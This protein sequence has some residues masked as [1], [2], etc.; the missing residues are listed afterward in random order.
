MSR[1]PKQR[2]AGTPQT[3]RGMPVYQLTVTLAHVE[4]PVWRRVRMPG[5]LPLGLF[6]EF[7]QATMGWR[8]MHLHRFEVA[9]RSL[10]PSSPDSEMGDEDLLTLTQAV[11]LAGP[12]FRYDYDFG[13]DWQHQINVE[14]VLSSPATTPTP[15]CVEGERGCPPEDCGGPGGYAELLDALRDP[16]HPRHEELLEWLK[17]INGPKAIFDPERFDLEAT[18]TRLRR[19]AKEHRHSR[20]MT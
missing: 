1:P 5:N 17:I 10:G 8:N 20:K 18:N 16:G 7:L 3:P 6:H 11:E 9:G 13:D 4:P 19:V 2:R 14:D 12:S 15:V